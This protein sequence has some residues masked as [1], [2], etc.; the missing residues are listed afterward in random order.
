M[1][2]PQGVKQ[3]VITIWATLLISGVVSLADKLT[4]Q[5]TEGMFFFT[6]IFYGLLCILPYKIGK[7][8]NP[9]RYVYVVLTVISFLIMA[10][11]AK[12]PQL[13]YIAGFLM[14]PVEIFIVYR[15]FTGEAKNWFA[16]SN[17]SA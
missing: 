8:S 6:L 1:N 4:G 13:D 3:A 11:G 12:M 17:Q 15:L 16:Q 10:S 5:I 9:A 7:R 2:Q 14:L